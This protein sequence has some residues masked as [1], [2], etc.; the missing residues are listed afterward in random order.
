MRYKGSRQSG[1]VQDRT[2]GNSGSS[3]GGLGGGLGDI[4]GRGGG[5]IG[6]SSGGGFG[7]GTGGG[8][9][10]GTGGG[11]GGGGLGG[12]GLSGKGCGGGGCGLIGLILV[13]LLIFGGGG[14]GGLF[15][16]GSSSGGNGGFGDIFGTDTGIQGVDYETRNVDSGVSDDRKEF[17]SV[18]F[19][20]LEDYWNEVFKE[21]GE[22]YTNPQLILYSGAVQSA[23]GYTSSQVG[24]FYCPGDQGVYLDMS[25]ADELANKYGAT[26][27]FALAYVLAH[28]VGHH[29]QNELGITS[30]L[31]RIR[32]QVSETE[33]NKY[34]VRCELQADYFAGCFAKYLEGETYNGQPILEAGDI[35]EAIEAAN[36]IGDDTLQKEHQGYVVPDS[37]THG[38]SAQRAA[39]FNRGL[40]YG[41]LEHGDTYS[42]AS[43]DL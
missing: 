4:F 27:D 36:A 21:N 9:G 2:G 34:S 11:L 38:T 35:E 33:Y 16:G 22:N 18:T 17:V 6:G 12:S 23:C 30:Q 19:A 40:K 39:W 3:G 24:P 31:D 41:D 15:G 10:R 14:L 28:E 37:F 29:V 25:F 13:A 32:Q 7:R 5:N 42:A 1:N 8:F 43:L 20:H 26:G